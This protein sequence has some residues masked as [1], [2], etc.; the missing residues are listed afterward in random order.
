MVANPRV[1]FLVVVGSSAGGIEA[2]S[3]LVAGLP[4]E[5]PA[6]MVLA[7]HLD[8]SHPSHLVEILAP[9]S[10]LPVRP[11]TPNSPLEPGVVLVAPP[12]QHVLIQDTQLALQPAEKSPRPSIDQL[13]T[14]AAEVFG[15]R[16][17]AIILSGTGSD[18]A[19]GAKVVHEAGGTV[20]VQNPTTALYPEMPLALAPTAVDLTTS[21][22]RMGPLLTQLVSEPAFPQA[23]E[24]HQVLAFL[25]E[26]IRRHA[27]L[28]FTRYK[29]PTLWRRLRRRLVVTG[30]DTLD[31][32][33]AYLHTHPEEYHQLATSFLIKVTAF[34]RDP[35]TFT[36]LREQ[37]LPAL[38]STARKSDRP[39]RC[40]SAGCA[41]GE[42][43]YSL[44]LLLADLVGDELEQLPIRI[45]ATDVDPAA[46]AFARAGRYS[47]AAVAAVPAD[48][49]VRFF[50]EVK[51]RYQ[52]NKPVR[53]LVTFGLHDLGQS[54][55]FGQLDL[56]LCRHVLLYF[57][58]ELEERALRL[59]AYSL[60]EGGTLV[61]GQDES[62]LKFPDY[63]V[64]QDRH[65]LYRRTSRRVSTLPRP[66]THVPAPPLLLSE[67]QP[68][69][70][71][72]PMPA[73]PRVA[74]PPR[75]LSE[76]F[77]LP[78]PVGVILVNRQYDIQAIN[79]AARDLCS[80][81]GP[82]QGEDILHLAQGAPPDA[83]R[84]VIDQAVRTGKPAAQEGVAVQDALTGEQRILHLRAIPRR[85]QEHPGK[86]ETILLVIDDQT[87]QVQRRLQVEQRLD[88]AQ[89]EVARLR[90]EVAMQTAAH[91]A[92]L[93][94]L[95]EN[96]RQTQEANLELTRINEAL[97]RTHDDDLA[98]LEEAQAEAEEAATLNEELQTTTE[99]L[100]ATNEEL[101]VTLEEVQA[102]NQQLQAAN[103]ELRR[104]ARN[105]D[106]KTASQPP[107]GPG[108]HAGTERS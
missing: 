96:H 2:L 42:E 71:D 56:I 21:V 85:G 17:I 26:E 14:S 15:E 23:A 72:V 36:L 73:P 86:I 94:H 84:T 12:G 49:R 78:L 82:A 4:A 64:V 60:R 57:T 90:Q 35:E 88:E 92:Q 53:S 28:D 99:E 103:D 18:G 3:K 25:L 47:H 68:W 75:S 65:P 100:Q 89:A 32:Y 76:A 29:L 43:A 66:V 11:V 61:L 38:V 106:V 74:L 54:A 31:A 48:L 8:A 81:Q 59:F 19:A 108:D 5:F 7:Q 55:P 91:T 79:Q 46:I 16:A 80:I 58:P 40:W 10:R 24:D 45:F 27:G 95:V 105:S 37:V 101:R 13:F 70:S 107:S 69:P 44:A 9:H 22:E 63:F 93:Q 98:L 39:L 87:E 104:Q 41:T 1:P 102:T 34:F 50:S 77:L 52:I 33:Q 30:A 20:L 97:L 62:P 6:A 67:R 51:G 83:L